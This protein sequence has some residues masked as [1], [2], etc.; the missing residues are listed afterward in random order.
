MFNFDKDFN[1][2]WA[3]T[4]AMV[5]QVLQNDLARLEQLLDPDTDF[6]KW[7]TQELKSRLQSNQMIEQTYLDIKQNL[8]LTKQNLLQM[9]LEKKLAQK[10]ADE[11]A[12]QQKLQQEEIQQNLKQIQTLQHIGTQVQQESQNYAERYGKT[13]PS[14]VPLNPTDQNYIENLRLHLE[15]ETET[16]IQQAVQDYRQSLR[17]IA[18]EEIELLLLQAEENLEKLK[19][20]NQ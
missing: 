15:S 16:F 12:H 11:I 9:V 7:K 19:Q 5:R 10:R 17:Q 4:P 3:E 1:R 2:R 13:M 20:N 6:E 18:Q 8:K 14:A